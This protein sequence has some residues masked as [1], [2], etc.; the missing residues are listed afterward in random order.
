NE[1]KI[2]SD[3]EVDPALRFDAFM[4]GVKDGGLRSVSSISIMVCY[5]V[6]NMN[7]R[8]TAEVIMQAMDEGMLANHFEVANAISKLIEAGT[9]TEAED[10]ALTLNANA[11][12]SIDLV[13]K[14]LPFTVRE[15]SIH[16][17]QK[18][19]AKETYKKEN[20]VVIV[21]NGGTYT[22]NMKIAGDKTDYLK[23][24]LYA[25]TIEQANTIK[26]RFLTDPVKFYDTVI[27]AIFANEE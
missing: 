1:N 21:N 16:L 12:E 7:G 17:V 13:E 11:K 24:S 3:S 23:L 9:I 20:E 6:A 22:V 27:E 5:I 8:V 10:G 15:R 25:P 14:D 26:E 4:G 18:I 2:I 19:L